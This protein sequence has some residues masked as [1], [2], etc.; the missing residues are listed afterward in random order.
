MVKNP[1]FLCQRKPS[2]R[3]AG[4]PD[5]LLASALRVG[6]LERAVSW[7]TEHF[8]CE[9]V[10]R[11]ERHAT[12]AFGDVQLQLQ[13]WDSDQPALAIVSPDVAQLGASQRRADGVRVLQLTDPWGNAIQVVDRVPS[14]DG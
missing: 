13:S 2:P 4:Q 7:Y 6:D 5:Q 9:V 11:D 14:A 3:P 8:R 10:Q 1:D 12:L